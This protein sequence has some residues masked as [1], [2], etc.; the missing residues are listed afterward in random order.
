MTWL[1]YAMPGTDLVAYASHASPIDYPTPP[2]T[3]KYPALT[4]AML[5]PGERERGVWV[6]SRPE[7]A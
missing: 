5:L 6:R 2:R 4:L 3:T 1:C 7:K